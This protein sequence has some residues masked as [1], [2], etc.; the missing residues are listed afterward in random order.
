MPVRKH[1]DDLLARLSD[2][3]YSALYSDPIRIVK[4]FRR[5][6]FSQ[7]PF[8]I[9]AFTNQIG[10]LYL[11]IALDETLADGNMEAFLLALKNIVDAK[12]SMQEVASNAEISGWTG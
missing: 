1:R 6:S 11:K 9:Q 8:T 12:E 7:S 10:L 3:E 5:K 4:G 2:P